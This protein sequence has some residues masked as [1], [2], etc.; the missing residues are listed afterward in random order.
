MFGNALARSEVW[1]FDS[2]FDRWF[3]SQ[4]E[5]C[6]TEKWGITLFRHTFL[7]LTLLVVETLWRQYS[8]V[9]AAAALTHETAAQ[10]LAHV[11]PWRIRLAAVDS[12][13]VAAVCRPG[14]WRCR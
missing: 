9:R 1:D 10:P 13:Q 14:S 4:K 12:N 7:C 2:G 6:M 5:K 3:G 8:A 11:A